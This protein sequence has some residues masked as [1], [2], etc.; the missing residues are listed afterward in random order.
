MAS[1]KKSHFLKAYRDQVCDVI[2]KKYK[3]LTKDDIKDEVYKILEREL[4]NPD[5]RLENSYTHE[6][7]D[8][9]LLSV[10]DWMIE[11]K[12]IVAANATF[13]KQHAVSKNPNALM[14][15]EFLVTRK[16]VKKEMF[17]LEDETSRLYKMKDLSQT[18][19]KKLANSFYGGNGMKASAFYNKWTAPCTTKSAQSIISTC[20]TCFEAFLA[21]NFSF[22][23][24][25]ECYY[26][27]N[28]VLK[29]EWVP[30]PWV[31]VPTL[32]M[33]HERLSEVCLLSDD[34]DKKFL[35][36]YLATLTPVELT[37]LYWKNNFL[38]FTKTHKEMRDLWDKIFYTV[39]NYD[40]MKDNNDF[41][42]V[43]DEYLDKIKA[44]K[45]PKKA[46]AKIRDYE[47]FCDPNNPPES[48]KDILNELN[49][50]YMRNVYVEYMYTDRIY[51]LKNF[52]RKV[53]TTIDTDSNFLSIDSFMEYCMDE[54]LKDDY[55]RDWLG[56]VFIGMNTMA[57]IITSAV[58]TELLFYGKMSNV[59]ESIRPRLNMKNEFFIVN[60]IL[61]KTKKRYLS[62]ILLREGVR[63]T[64]PKYDVKGFDFKKAST[65]ESA[66][67]FFM[68][69]VE[70]IILEPENVDVTLLLEELKKFRKQVKESIM[71][72]DH[73]YLP[74]ANAKELEAYDEPGREQSI[75][76]ALGWNI[77]YPDRA[78][79]LPIK[80]SI[81]KTNIHTLDDI[82]P[83]K[84]TEPEIYENIKREIFGDRSGIFR[85]VKGGK[86][87]CEGLA[88]L[89][90]PLYERIPEWII[91]YID[92]TTVIN[93]V[94][95]PFKSVTETF[96]IPSIE[97]GVTTRKTAGF[98]NIIKI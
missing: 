54:L 69:V 37:K 1:F 83:L 85:K 7:Q 93:S 47:A 84:K 16:K 15:D 20:E 71:K 6:A 14:V 44:D 57:Y 12:P 67:K 74:L 32:D 41:S 97:E 65:S 96:N 92:Y 53:V 63:L 8:T 55:G 75:R 61:A 11:T 23:D 59:E 98:S 95:A 90:I 34:E 33:V 70:D 36:D 3:E 42:V 31:K 87:T 17:A 46:W 52:T 58:T 27:I 78:V 19:Y 9:K 73:Q 66:S 81:L 39:K 82:A 88:V 25:N 49:G 29:E 40:Y 89:G 80:L 51:K 2:L 5:A 64:K 94:M 30:E 50:Y 68:H 86:D 13:F 79:E 60:L 77:C 62:K 91:P 76:G 28:I 48:I 72:G 24:I 4:V 38:L 35:Y 10:I 21:D 26:W 22:V 56:N 43:S 18:N 45:N